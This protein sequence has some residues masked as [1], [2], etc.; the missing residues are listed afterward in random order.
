MKTGTFTKI[1]KHLKKNHDPGDGYDVQK[2]LSNSEYKAIESS[3]IENYP[4]YRSG[5]DNSK[6]Q[7]DLKHAVNDI[8]ARLRTSRITYAPWLNE[9]IGLNGCR[10]LEIGCG[11]GT[12][13]IALAELGAEVSG[14]DMDESAIGAA[15]DLCG[16]FNVNARLFTGNAENV[17]SEL[18]NQQFDLVLF[19]ATLEHMLYGERINCIKKYY[20]HITDNG[21]MGIFETPNRLWY[22]DAH[23]GMLPFFHWLQ[24]DMALDYL[25][26][27]QSEEPKNSNTKRPDIHNLQLAR[28]GR[29]FSYHELEIALNISAEK[30]NVTGYIAPSFVTSL[31]QSFHEI[32]ASLNPNI[33]KGFFYPFI[34]VLIKKTSGKSSAEISDR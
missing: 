1:I 34:D 30:I 16:I 31:D 8:I 32:L 18:N 3:I 12:S 14:I 11:T 6:N 25:K 33:S 7:T 28:M 9:K 21:Y 4:Q 20:N 5:E 15:R 19:V 22:F 13:L 23:T 24:D 17:I 2:N 27:G 29:G 10:V 26:I